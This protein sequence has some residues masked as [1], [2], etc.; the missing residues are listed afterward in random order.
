MNEPVDEAPK[1]QVKPDIDTVISDFY[2]VCDTYWFFRLNGDQWW[3]ITAQCAHG[4]YNQSSAGITS[5][6]EAF[7]KLYEKVYEDHQGI[8]IVE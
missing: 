5:L 1:Y 4:N 8:E 6:T 2:D 7:T 3:M